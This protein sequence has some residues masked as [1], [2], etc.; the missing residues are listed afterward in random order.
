[1][2][3][4]FQVVGFAC[5]VALVAGAVIPGVSCHVYFGTTEGAK[6]WHK[7]RAGE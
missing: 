7:E 1:M 6:E 5:V 4:F 2:S 3:G